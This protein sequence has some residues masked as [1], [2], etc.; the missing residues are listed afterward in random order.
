MVFNEEI[1]EKLRNKREGTGSNGYLVCDTC[2]GSYE[3][4]NG[5][6]PEDFSSKC[7]CG[8]NLKHNTTDKN[9]RSPEDLEY[10]KHNRS[11][12]ASYVL[13]VL[14]VPFAFIG[15]IYLITRDNKR[16]KYNGKIILV[17]SSFGIILL[18]LRAIFM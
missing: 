14:F 6:K 7:E 1:K 4:Q 5:E 11:I 18:I 16:A 2:K 9:F 8:G 3:L 10:K 12:I 13:I 17:I 15:S